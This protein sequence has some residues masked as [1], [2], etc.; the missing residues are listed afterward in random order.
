MKDQRSRNPILLRGIDRRPQDSVA[1]GTLLDIINMRFTNNALRPVPPKAVMT[2]T[3]PGFVIKYKHVISE[4]KYAYW[5][6]ISGHLAYA[7]YINDV[8]DSAN[9]TFQDITGDA[10]FSN[11]GNVCLISD[12]DQEKSFVM[13]FD[14]NSNTYRP[15]DA[16]LPDMPHLSYQRVAH[17]AD[18][19]SKSEE[20][21]WGTYSDADYTRCEDAFKGM[22]QDCLS[23]KNKLGYLTGRFLIRCAWELFDG[24]IV[25]HSTP[26]YLTVSEIE[27]LF[28]GGA[29]M[30]PNVKFTG[31]TLQYMLDIAAADLATVK[32]QFA[33]IVTSLNIY[34][35]KPQPLRETRPSAW[36]PD[37]WYS[38][39]IPDGFGSGN[40][41]NHVKDEVIYFELV[42]INLTDLIAETWANAS[43]SDASTL[44]S[45][46]VL[47][48]GNLSVHRLFGKSLFSYNQR[49]FFGNIKNTLFQGTTLRG[50]LY[51]GSANT[52]G[53]EY[54]IG[55]S[56]D[57]D[58]PDGIKR[59]FTGWQSCTYYATGT[60]N[61][62]FTTHD[63]VLGYPDARAKKWNIWYK[64]GAGIIRHCILSGGARNIQDIPMTS[65]YGMNFSFVLP[66]DHLDLDSWGCVDGVEGDWPIEAINES[67]DYWDG[68]R[69]QACEFQNPYY[70]PA[71]NSYR[72]EGFIL[73]MAT[74][75]VPLSLG[76]F[77]EYPIF[78]FTNQGIW[79]LSMGSGVT[80]IQ[81]ISPLSGVICTNSKSIIGI[82]GGVIFQSNEGLMIIS[83][84]NPVSI[85]DPIIGPP[86]SPL[87]G[88]LDYEKCINNPNTYQPKAFIDGISFET[89]ANDANIAFVNVN[90]PNS[91]EKEIIISN[92][93]Y[94]YSYVYNLIA[95]S[96]YRITQSWDNL[97]HDFPKTYG[98]KYSG[99]SYSLNDLT[100]EQTNQQILTH[101]ET[102]SMKF[103]EEISFKKL[104]RTMLYGYIHPP[105]EKPYTFFIFGSTDGLLWTVQQA[106]QLITPGDKVVLGR[107]SFS[108]RSYIFIIGGYLLDDSYIQGLII[109]AEKRYNDKL[110]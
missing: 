41:Y 34:L 24:S 104:L 103:S 88:Q 9:L 44:T 78:V 46:I 54:F 61:I 66:V 65:L 81:N 49:I 71:I 106:S 67:K 86:A 20:L 4:T 19:E 6:I 18:D 92:P 14:H 80:L 102:R 62:H 25:C 28:H 42:K 99:G 72:V 37:Q 2:G 17:N 98:S 109:D 31:Y 51:P 79:T 101:I 33:G 82:D 105:T 73:G 23:R 35:S 94:N 60:G 15:F 5:G 76:Q 16:F 53:A 75:V 68:D 39:T 83:G 12:L 26:Q 36:T 58:T 52:P 57:I 100:L 22:A 29:H 95:K 87:T 91:L 21:D 13:L 107:T 96:W 56:Y 108:C 97:I 1:D 89:Y 90:L 55:Y 8:Y 70:Y 27:A 50:S 7:L 43:V 69:I 59:V 40:I 3:V 32:T 77:G 110:R 48:A 64:N 84:K 47:P 11:M 93:N 38:M 74:N 85:S 63:H 30:W 45:G 10:L